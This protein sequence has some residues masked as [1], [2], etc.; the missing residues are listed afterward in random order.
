[1]SD[2]CS[3]AYIPD[4]SSIYDSRADYLVSSNTRVFNVSNNS[5]AEITTA[6]SPTAMFSAG[7]M[8]LSGSSSLLVGGKAQDGWIGMN[9]L[10]IWEYSSWSFTSTADSS[11]VDSRTDPLVL[12]LDSPANTSQTVSK[13]CL[14]IGGKVNSHLSLPFIAGLSLNDTT[15]W[16]WN[17]SLNQSIIDSQS[18]VLGAVT[19]ENTLITITDFSSNSKRDTGYVLSYFDTESW[20]QVSG[21]TPSADG[22]STST[23]TSTSTT[24]ATSSATTSTTASS[25]T[26]TISSG[27]KIALST[28]LPLGALFAAAATLGFLFYRKRKREQNDLLPAPRPLTLS[29]YFGG[30][31]SFENIMLN[32]NE[33]KRTE[34]INS[35]RE[36]R[37]I[38]EQQEQQQQQLEQNQQLYMQG[39]SQQPYM[40]ISDP[41]QIGAIPGT[42]L[43]IISIGAGPHDAYDNPF[44]NSNDM[45]V[46][47]DMYETHE[48][49]ESYPNPTQAEA[50]YTPPKRASTM[51]SAS[52]TLAN[53]FTGRR[54][55]S[56]TAVPVRS[57]SI[58]SAYTDTGLS[59]RPSPHADTPPAALLFADD[60]DDDDGHDDFF[61]GRDVQVLV[62]S[63]RR[64][65]LRITNPDPDSLS[66]ASSEH[67]TIAS[68]KIK[69]K[70]KGYGQLTDQYYAVPERTA[71]LSRQ[72]STT[73]SITSQAPESPLTGLL[74]HH[75]EERDLADARI[76]SRAVSSGSSYSFR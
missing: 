60:H 62:S 51:R 11:Y 16:T 14:V 3:I 20:S 43:G 57:Q 13:A 36:K 52:A 49:T 75:Q 40:A 17:G 4:P 29:P 12:P 35:W 6:S 47:N 39:Y 25:S 34:S 61:L 45:Y 32:G 73:A 31:A 26:M 15:G 27:G 5:F 37:I 69:K 7:V 21:Y 10:A 1:M 54:T 59:M 24:A 67:S 71:T 74:E 8:R 28:V 46:T 64:T 50:T 44:Y 63:K 66:R 76:G 55:K 58:T 56:S 2:N 48:Q 38:Y 23:S 33:S 9:Q 70:R 53:Y 19:F 30:A 41:N 65:R 22:S 42:D 18:S 72:N 68:L